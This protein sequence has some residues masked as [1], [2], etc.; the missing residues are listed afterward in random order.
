MNE[1]VDLSTGEIIPAPSQL[2]PFD[3]GGP[4]LP[5]G[6]RIMFDEKLYAVCDR[7]AERMSKAQGITPP[8]LLGKKEACFF[9]VTAAL[10]WRLDPMYVAKKTY[11]TPGGQVGHYGSLINAIIEQSGRLEPSTGGVRAE[12][13]GDWSIDRKSVV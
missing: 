7:T 5:M 8:H 10:N 13:V 9:V 4:P 12:H 1:H 6:V 3:A 11:Q 2:S